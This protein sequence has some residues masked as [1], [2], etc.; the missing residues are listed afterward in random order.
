MKLTER[1]EVFKEPS[2]AIELKKP[3]VINKLYCSVLLSAPIVR[4]N[5]LEGSKLVMENEN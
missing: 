4:E 5:H 1:P 3:F 2:V